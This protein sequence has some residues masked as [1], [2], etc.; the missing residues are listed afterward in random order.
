MVLV[1]LLDLLNMVV[2]NPY[3]IQAARQTGMSVAEVNRTATRAVITD[4]E[5]R[6][7][8]Y[9]T[10]QEYEEALHEFLNSN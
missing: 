5:A 10:A 6:K 3:A 4:E 2:W 8:G 9:D 7:R 1:N